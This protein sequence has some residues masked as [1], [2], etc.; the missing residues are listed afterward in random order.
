[1]KANELFS[2]KELPE[3]QIIFSKRLTYERRAKRSMKV[4]KHSLKIFNVDEIKSFKYYIP[5]YNVY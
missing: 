4:I 3:S 2:N 1:M 5:F